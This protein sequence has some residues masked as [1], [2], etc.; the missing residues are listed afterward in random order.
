[1]EDQATWHTSTTLVYTEHNEAQTV[2]L[3]VNE[4][5]LAEIGIVL[6]DIEKILQ[7]NLWLYIL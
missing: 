4:R 2:A 7:L 5:D 3:F 1:M 6:V